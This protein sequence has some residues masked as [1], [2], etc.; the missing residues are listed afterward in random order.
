MFS[1]ILLFALAALSFPAALA[2]Q[3]TSERPLDPACPQGDLA[4]PRTPGSVCIGRLTDDYAFSFI[5][6]REAV[7]I[8]AMDAILRERAVEGEAWIGR[9]VTE[10]AEYRDEGTRY[11]YESG[12]T[13]D[14]VTPELAAFSG[15]TSYFAGGAHG[16]FEADAILFDR[17]AG[18][19]VRL[20]D[21]FEPGLFDYRLFGHRLTGMQA[22]QERFCRALTQEVRDRRGNADEPIVCPALEGTP[23]TLVC[24]RDTGRVTSLM[25]LINPYV[26]GSWAEG[27]YEIEVPLDPQIIDH[28]WR[29]YRPTF[30]LHQESGARPRRHGC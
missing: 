18:R 2:A 22:V 30:G 14:A 25:A 7:A 1:R 23:V 8:P 24:Q 21:L 16:G 5:Y 10:R 13:A 11:T 19:P 6:P 4:V 20:M 3:E 29:R 28:M 26:V 27:P 9:Q 12:W 15:T 17:L